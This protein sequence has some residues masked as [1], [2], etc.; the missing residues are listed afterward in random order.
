MRQKRFD[1]G[2]LAA[3]TLEFCVGHVEPVEY[4]RLKIFQVTPG[5]DLDFMKSRF[6]LEM[7]KTHV[8]FYAAK[9]KIRDA[10][11]ARHLQTHLGREVLQFFQSRVG[12]SQHT[13]VVPAAKSPVGCQH[14]QYGLFCFRSGRQERV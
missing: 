13:A 3:G 4:A 7:S 2:E 12:Q 10:A 9:A 1:H 8:R 11:L 6:V 5:K 14:Q